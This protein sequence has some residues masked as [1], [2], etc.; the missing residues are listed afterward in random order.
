MPRS[1]VVPPLARPLARPLVLAHRGA[2]TVAPENTLEAFSTALDQG[3]AGVELD[4]HRAADDGLV[5]HHDAEA[6]GLGIL[7]ERSLVEIREARPDIPTLGEVLDVCRGSLVN[8]EIK[9]LPTDADYDA[10]DRVAEHVVELLDARDRRDD[11]LVSS[12]NL[13]TVDRVRALE[14]SIPTGFLSM[15][16]PF[17]GIALCAERGHGSLHPFF[18]LLGQDTAVPIVTRAREVDVAINVWTVNDEEEMVRL[19]AAGV[20]AIITDVPDVAL[21][22]LS[23]G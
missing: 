11:V 1:P 8:V 19:A 16:D 6:L 13:A 12:F 4:V 20:A 23:A 14:P 17:E 5:V 3:A 7:A 22:V 2:R 9:N 15:L 18:A 10:A 21:R